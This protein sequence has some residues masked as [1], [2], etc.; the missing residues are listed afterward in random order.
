[1]VAASLMVFRRRHPEW[2]HPFR[3]P[4][5]PLDPLASMAATAF[6]MVSMAS[7]GALEVIAGLCLML[8][9]LPVLCFV[10]ATSRAGPEVITPNPLN[11]RVN[12]RCRFPR[13]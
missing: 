13:Q 6:L 12:R 2:A 9:G 8:L 4:G 5:Y 10:P 3:V 7:S 1:M 11:P